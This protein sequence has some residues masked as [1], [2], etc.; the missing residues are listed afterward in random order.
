MAQFQHLTLVIALTA[1]LTAFAPPASANSVNLDFK[2]W[3]NAVNK[4]A[5]FNAKINDGEFST[6]ITTLPMP[7]GP[8]GLMASNLRMP[9]FVTFGAGT[10]PLSAGSDEL[11]FGGTAGVAVVR[12]GQT[13][14]LVDTSA[15][16][17]LRQ[18]LFADGWLLGGVVSA[19]AAAG[20]LDYLLSTPVSHDIDLTDMLSSAFD[21]IPPVSELRIRTSYDTLRLD[22]VSFAFLWDA[23]NRGNF[24]LPA[25]ETLLTSPLIPVFGSITWSAT[26]QLEVINAGYSDAEF[27]AAREWVAA[28][29]RSPAI[30]VGYNL[31]IY[32]LA[33]SAVPE[34]TGCFMWLGGLALL[35]SASRRRSR[36]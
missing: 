15:S 34:P 9:A 35:V 19:D 31:S 2:L 12:D 3:G 36:G 6:Y 1:T 23:G 33:V 20:R 24:E 10:S 14:E 27:A 8:E 32:D 22:D 16:I 7:D 18:E 4:A 5:W 21:S 26:L 30:T 28:N 13:L 29:L 17:I 25:Y 11:R